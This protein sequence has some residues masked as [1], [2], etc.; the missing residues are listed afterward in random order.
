VFKEGKKTP[1]RGGE[2]E[3][4]KG[5][6]LIGGGGTTLRTAAQAKPSRRKPSMAAWPGLQGMGSPKKGRRSK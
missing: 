6:Q 1:V 2:L 5:G 4:G 3:E